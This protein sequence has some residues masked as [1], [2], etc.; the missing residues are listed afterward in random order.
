MSLLLSLIGAI[1]RTPFIISLT[2]LLSTAFV[3]CSE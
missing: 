1:N 2:A 3:V